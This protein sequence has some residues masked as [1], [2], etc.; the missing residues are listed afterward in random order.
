[1]FHDQLVIVTGAS[2]AV[3]GTLVTRLLAAGARVGALDRA[4]PA[5]PGGLSAERFVGLGADL[6][7]ERA[8]EA[9]FQQLVDALGP[10][11]ALA[12]VAGTWRGG[13]PVA[14]TSLELFDGLLATN[15]RSAFLCSRAAMR[16]LQPGGRVASVAALTAFSGTNTGGSA[17]YAVSKAGVLALSRAL[18]EEGRA[19]NIRSNAIA[20]GTIRT[21]ANEAAMP[22]ADVSSWATLDE[23]ADALLFALGPD[24]PVS[25]AVLTV[26]GRQ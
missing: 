15:L 11:H 6:T 7:D 23:V 8:V 19:A 14:E 24:C 4:A 16:R 22:A 5:R 26:P 10:L 13:Q 1:M 18:A 9:A 25:G 12:N 21:R 2:G 20:P 3:G 17:A